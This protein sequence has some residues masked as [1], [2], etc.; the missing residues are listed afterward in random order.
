MT[1][2]MVM[3]VPLAAGDELSFQPGGLHVMLVG[4]KQELKVG[5]EFELILH[6]KSHADIKVNVKV[7]N[8][9]PTGDENGHE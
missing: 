2:N 5:D 3:S 8:Q 4:V 9:A 1:M 7:D 6:F